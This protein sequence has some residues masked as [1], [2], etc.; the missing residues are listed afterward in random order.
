MLPLAYG[1]VV[2]TSLVVHG[3]VNVR[4]VDVSVM[5]MSVSGAWRFDVLVLIIY[6]RFFVLAAHT[7]ATAYGIAE[8]AAD[9]IKATYGAP[10]ASTDGSTT[11][12]G[13]SSSP[14]GSDSGNKSNNNVATT[15]TLSTGTKIAIGA[16][17]AVAA[18]ALIAVRSL[19][20]SHYLG[21]ICVLAGPSPSP[22]PQR[23]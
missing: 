21:L 6:W 9:L 1:G 19:C 18:I 4:V 13:S 17:S 14:S 23:K 3:T 22:P 8:R 2:N 15:S 16:G 7:M 20:V 12:S 5:P 11:D 10:S